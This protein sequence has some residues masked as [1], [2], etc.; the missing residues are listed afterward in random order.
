V[1]DRAGRLVGL[2][3]R[4]PVAPRLIA[5]VMPPT[6]YPTV[7]ATAVAA[8]LK[9]SGIGSALPPS[10]APV[11]TATPGAAVAPVL[12]AVVDLQCGP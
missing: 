6:R 2:V 3:A 12:A 11:A 10:A 1:L 8:F 5:G 7:P 4:A 9:R